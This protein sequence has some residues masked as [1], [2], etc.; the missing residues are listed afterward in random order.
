MNERTRFQPV[1][2]EIAKRYGTVI[3]L[4]KN[5]EVL[6]EI[7]REYGSRFNQDGTGGVSP[8]SIAVAGPGTPKRVELTDVMQAVLKLQRD[9]K[10]IG[11]Q[12]GRLQGGR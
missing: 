3:D 12:V 11:S 9:V 2:G 4:D 5:P 7:V 8:S 10:D 1:L 6:V